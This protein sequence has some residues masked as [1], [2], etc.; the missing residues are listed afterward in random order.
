MD[1]LY[2]PTP[3]FG[4]HLD[5]RF[6]PFAMEFG[7]IRQVGQPECPGGPRQ[8]A[9]VVQDRVTQVCQLGVWRGG[10]TRECAGGGDEF[11]GDG[12]SCGGGVQS[13]MAN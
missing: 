3:C 2:H 1:Y 11:G 9:Q 6:H 13:E 12:V 7:S 4:S 10:S 8:S 5:G